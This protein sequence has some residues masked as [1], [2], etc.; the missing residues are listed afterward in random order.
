VVVLPVAAAIFAFWF[1]LATW[2]AAS[3][4][5]VALRVWSVAL[6]EFGAACLAL[7]WGIAFGWTPLV[8]R[9]FYLFGAVL[10]VAWLAL[11]TIWL[12]APRWFALVFNVAFAAGAGISTALVMTSALVPE[13]LQE[14]ASAQLPHPREVMGDVPRT[15]SRIF[16]IGGSAIVLVGMSI[17]VLRRQYAGGLAL[18]ALGVVIAG[19]ASEFARAGDVAPFCAG[20]ALGIAVMY[21]GFVRTRSVRN[22]GAK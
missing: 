12:L 17:G 15:L 6:A 4:R 16:S 13:A 1:A 10:N 9:V 2:R 5:N 21:A 3:D 20:L 7:A 11:G 14:L 18:L 8:Y 22:G 19:V